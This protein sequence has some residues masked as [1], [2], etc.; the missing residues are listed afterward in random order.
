MKKQGKK[1]KGKVMG[2]TPVQRIGMNATA[3][4]ELWAYSL[5]AAA[6]GASV[7]AVDD[8]LGMALPASKAVQALIA[9]RAT[10]EDWARVSKI[11]YALI[12][13]RRQGVISK[14]ST[15][16][17]ETISQAID[18]AL[19]R[20][21]QTRSNVLT[22][23]EVEALEVLNAAWIDAIGATEISK[24]VDASEYATRRLSQE[25]RTARHPKALALEVCAV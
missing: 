1:F 17:L 8:R 23:A 21:S 6:C 12:Y 15:E 14:N 18:T 11:A 5:R 2:L 4:P 19:K 22:P 10:R 24:L 16:A 13:L 3:A 20:Q 7:A 9:S 25:Y